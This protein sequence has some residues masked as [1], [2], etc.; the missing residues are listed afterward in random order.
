MRQVRVQSKHPFI[1]APFLTRR[2]PLRQVRVQ[3]KL[4]HSEKMVASLTRQLDD[5]LA[6]SGE[7]MRELSGIKNSLDEVKSALV[8]SEARELDMTQRCEF[9][10]PRP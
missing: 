1:D 6:K 5:E 3:S 8:L 2:N 10:G 4:V 9:R 7:L